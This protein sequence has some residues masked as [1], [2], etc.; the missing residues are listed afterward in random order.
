VPKARLSF[1]ALGVL[2]VAVAGPVRADEPEE[3]AWRPTTSGP[4]VTMT[5]PLTAKGQLTFQPLL[6]A[7]FQR[8]S[9]D[10]ASGYAPF[11]GSG[12]SLSLTIFCEY[13]FSE[14]VAAGVQFTG[15]H[16]R[17]WLAGTS[18]AT[19]GLGDALAFVR[20]ALPLP[21]SRWLPELSCFAQ[22]KAP[23]G[24]A[25]ALDPA[26]LGTDAMGTGTWE[27]TAGVDLTH[28]L[29]PVVVHV[30]LFANRAFEGMFDGV[31]RQPGLAFLWAAS[32]EVPLEVPVWPNH[33]GLMTELSGRFQDDARVA[34][35]AARGS[36]VRELTVGAGVEAIFSDQV[37]L[38]VG[39]QRTLWGANLPAI[40]VLG[41][42]LVSTR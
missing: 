2:L 26:R 10:A 37:Q 31:P 14:R 18:A 28:Y 40:D 6:F 22:V 25:D 32:V 13:G 21:P 9:F 39:Y 38:L 34:G 23:L 41:V 11:E 15:L 8:G 16:N 3:E 33:W 42:T 7:A 20:Y 30:D 27:F 29:R 4:F 36:A 1:A 5:A 24:R 17:L 12:Q 35:T 19:T